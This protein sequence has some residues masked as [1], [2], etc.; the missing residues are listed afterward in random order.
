MT[1]VTIWSDFGIREY[2]VCHFFHCF[3]IYLPWSDG[4][5]SHDLSFYILSFKPAFSFSTFTFIRRIFSSS[6]L[7]AVRVVSSAYVKLLIFL[8]AIVI[9]ACASS[10]LALHMMYSAYKLNKQGNNIQLWHTPFPICNQSAVPCLVATIASSPAYRF[11]RRQ[12]RWFSIPISLRIFHSFSWSTQSKALAQSMKQ[13]KMYFWNSL[14]FSMSQWMLAVW[15][16]V[17][18][19]V[20]VCLVVSDSLW[21]HGLQSTS[22]SVLE[23]VY[24]KGFPGGA[25]AKESACQWGVSRDVGPIPGL[26]WSPGIGNGNPL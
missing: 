20:H 1:A 14:S 21:H 25:S 15:Y 4:T 10:S 5:T 24:N 18:V 6:S 13:K 7:S 9:P 26:G 19:C 16:L 11:F 3:L 17:P 12:V 23:S 22:S 2:K 8:L